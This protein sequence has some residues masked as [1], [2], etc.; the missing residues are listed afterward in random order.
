MSQIHQI[1]L[2]AAGKPPVRQRLLHLLKGGGGGV[3][4]IP[5]VEHQLVAQPLNVADNPHLQLQRAPLHRYRDI[6]LL[7]L[8]HIA[9][10]A[11]EPL[12][13]GEIVQAA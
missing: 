9:Q 7:P 12:G 1:S 6:G 11:G 10:A 5:G 13:E 4:A 2:V 3:D 8:L